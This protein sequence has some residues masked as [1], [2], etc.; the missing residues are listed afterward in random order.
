MVSGV[1][2]GGSWCACLDGDEIERMM[3]ESD[4]MRLPVTMISIKCVRATNVSVEMGRTVN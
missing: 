2:G 1:V 4:G 3:A